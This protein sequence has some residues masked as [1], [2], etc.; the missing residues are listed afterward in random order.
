MDERPEPERRTRRKEPESR[1]KQLLPFLSVI[2]VT[3]CVSWFAFA[4]VSGVPV[5]FANGSGTSS[6][7]SGGGNSGPD[8]VYLTINGGCA[9]CPGPFNTSD[10]LSPANFSVPA[11]T[12]II[13]TIVN[14][15]NG[16]NPGGNGTPSPSPQVQG[17]LGNVEYQNATPPDNWGTPVTTMPL[18]D[19]SH[20]FSSSPAGVPMATGGFNVPIP[21][22]EGPQ[23]TSVTFKMFFNQTGALNWYCNAPCDPWSMSQ[24]GFMQ[25]TITVVG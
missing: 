4:M 19:V 11:H 15:D 1:V 10:Q 3:A 16:Q 14:F 22:N 8:F 5:G 13:F 17:V 7:S 23:G 6:S 2:V 9:W 20:T 25:G 21:A 18:G 24:A 12:L